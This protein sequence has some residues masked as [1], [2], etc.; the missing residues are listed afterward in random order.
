MDI[1]ATIKSVLDPIVSNKFQAYDSP[2]DTYCTYFVYNEQ[3]EAW[4]ENESIS[5]GYYVQV[6]I[7]SKGNY[8]TLYQQV[9]AAMVSA[10]F[11][12]SYAQDLYE[13]DTKIF[14]KAIRFNVFDEVSTY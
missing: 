2:P 13:N 7:W 9:K 6:D 1:L 10:G 11:H 8:S 3:G 4:A 5:T 12:F 14:H